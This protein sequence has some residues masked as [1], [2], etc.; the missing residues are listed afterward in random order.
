MRLRH[1]TWA[2]GLTPPRLC[3]GLRRKQSTKDVSE[4]DMTI[5]NFFY[6]GC[7]LCDATQVNEKTFFIEVASSATLRK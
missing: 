7:V 4:H 2:N 5:V 3:T 1:H 6:R